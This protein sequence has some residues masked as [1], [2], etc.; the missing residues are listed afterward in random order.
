MR[1]SPRAATMA[2]V[3]YVPNPVPEV[4]RTFAISASRPCRIPALTTRTAIVDGN[5]VGEQPCHARP[6]RGLRSAPVALDRLACRVF[7]PPRLWLPLL[8]SGVRASSSASAASMSSMSKN[9]CSAIRPSSSR[10]Y[11]WSNSSCGDP[12]LTSA[13]PTSSRV[14]ARRSPRTATLLDGDAPLDLT[15]TSYLAGPFARRNIEPLLKPTIFRRLSMKTSGA[16]SSSNSSHASRSTAASSRAIARTHALSSSTLGG[17]GWSWDRREIPHAKDA[18]AL[19]ASAAAPFRSYRST[20]RSA[21][22]RAPAASPAAPKTVA[23][24]T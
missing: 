14:R 7:E 18:R 4:A 23:S 13:V 1:R 8:E 20:A 10:P 6:S 24:E 21:A 5:V 22:A 2:D 11:T 9:T 15:K 17:F 19:S 12:G 3:M 16:M